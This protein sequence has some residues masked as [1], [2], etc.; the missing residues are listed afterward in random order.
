MPMPACAMA[1]PHTARGSPFARAQALPIRV[2]NSC[3]RSAMS[4]SAAPMVQAAKA[5]PMA[6]STLCPVSNSAVKNMPSAS[7]HAHHSRCSTG[8]NCA[9]FHGI[10][11]PAAIASRSGT[12]SGK[13]AMLK[14]GGPTETFALNSASANIG[15]SVPTKTTAVME[16]TSRLFSTIAPSREIGAKMPVGT[17]TWARQANSRKAPAM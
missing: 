4:V 17:I 3:V 12:T 16:Q 6:G 13:D 10:S 9:R 2:R 15:H 1:A 14:K 11:G 7:R 8:H 5:K